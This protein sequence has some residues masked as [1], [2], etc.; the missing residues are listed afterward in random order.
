MERTEGEGG[1]ELE[2]G[3]GRKYT[4][5]LVGLVYRGDVLTSSFF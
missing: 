4:D 1:V 3:L 5:Y 2:V